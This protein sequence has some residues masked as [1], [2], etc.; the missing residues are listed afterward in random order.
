MPVPAGASAPG[1]AALIGEETLAGWPLFQW[2]GCSLAVRWFGWPAVALE[3]F[4]VEQRIDF[5][6]VAWPESW[7]L[8]GGV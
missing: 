8:T 7:P 3:T 6:L 1:V 5:H 4:G 2:P